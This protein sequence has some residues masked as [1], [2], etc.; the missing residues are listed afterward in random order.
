MIGTSTFLFLL[1]CGSPHYSDGKPGMAS[2][3]EGLHSPKRKLK[4]TVHFTIEGSPFSSPQLCHGRPFVRPVWYAWFH[5]HFG[6]K[7]QNRAVGAGKRIVCLSLVGLSRGMSRCCLGVCIPVSYAS[8]IWLHVTTGRLFCFLRVVLDREGD[9]VAKN[10][11]LPC[12]SSSRR[13]HSTRLDCV[14]EEGSRIAEMHTRGSE[15]LTQRQ[16][17]HSLWVML[18]CL[19]KE[20]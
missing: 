3:R 7:Q 17:S 15:R 9:G 1:L 18:S 6:P 4:H 19:V 8:V 13:V 11:R 2:Y 5:S 12:L 10:E 14:N 20:A 16:R